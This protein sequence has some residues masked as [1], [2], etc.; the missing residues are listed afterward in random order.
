MCG[1]TGWIDFGRDLRTASAAIA[2]MTATMS[3]RGPDAE[4]TWIG[5]HAALG[6][7]R[8]AVIDLENGTQPMLDDPDRDP[9]AV[10][11]YSGEVYNFQELRDEL[12]ARGHR[13]RT[14]SDTEVVL[15]G[16]LEWGEG[17]PERLVG[18]FAFAVWDNRD[19]RLLLVRDRLG[20][21]PLYYYPTPR[22]VLFGSEPKAI[23][24]HPEARA[25]LGTTGLQELMTWVNTPGQA[26]FEGMR[27]VL[28]GHVLRFDRT[29][30]SETAYWRLPATAHR[31]DRATTVE[32]VRRLLRRAVAG[33]TVADVPLCS[34]LSG[35]LDSSTVTAYAAEALAER[36]EGPL[37]SFAVGFSRPGIP[38]QDPAEDASFAAKLAATVGTAHET[39]TLNAADL[40][41]PAARLAVLRARDLPLGLADMDTSLYLLFRTVRR[42]STVALSGEGADELFGGYPWFHDHG[43]TTA[44]TFPW[45]HHSAP[46]DVS[47]PSFLDPDLPRRLALDDYR[48]DRY[49]EAVREV[50]A[51]A[52]ENELDA[53]M[54]RV[55]HLF[56]TRF[57]PMLLERKDRMSMAVG[58]EVRVPFCDHRLVE[59]VFN[60]PWSTKSFDGREKSLLRA[61]VAGTVPGFVLDR[62]K[63]PYPAIVDPAYD[64]AMRQKLG[65]LMADSNA[66]V[67]PLMEQSS[68]RAAYALVEQAEPSQLQ[69]LRLGFESLLRINDWMREYRVELL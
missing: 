5:P 17:L 46:I 11:T 66:P 26:I 14:R 56:L 57:M 6:H 52:G 35:G 28:P 33:Q 53:R 18:M 47:G 48:A 19:Q 41:D 39:I 4:G 42:H 55:S 65:D 12:A 44:D 31:D 30:T 3:C 60:V 40:T 67:R 2:S 58:L 20:V 62:R 16:Y 24:A 34:L 8:L 61:A 9:T 37:R 13:F 59:Y 32:T 29:S 27:S 10:I 64:Q 69:F 1:I 68:A 25:Q 15:R 43:A 45:M 21:K 22:G 63:T 38:G 50:P 7:R 23:L 51:L 49:A 54:R 36:G